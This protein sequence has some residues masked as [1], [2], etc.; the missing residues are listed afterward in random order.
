MELRILIA[1]C[2]AVAQK[3]YRGPLQTLERRR[4]ARIVGVVDYHATHAQSLRTA[5][6][7]AIVFDDLRSGLQK[8]SPHLTLVLTPAHLHAEH[9]QESFRY[10]SNVLCEKPMATSTHDCEQ[11]IAAAAT[12]QRLLAV[13]MV[14]RFFPAFHQLRELVQSGAFGTVVSFE[15]REGRRFDWDVT[16]PAAFRRRDDGGTGVLFDIGPHVID[17]L[18]WTFGHLMAKKYADDAGQGVDSNVILEVQS[19]TTS[20]LI[21]LS[22]DSPLRNELRVNGTKLQAVLRVDQFD[23]LAINAA[24][25]F[26]EVSI[27]PSFAADVKNPSVARYIPHTY[28]QAVYCQLIQMLR[29]IELN[30]SPAVDGVSGLQTIRLLES[31]LALA[32][33]VPMPWL[34]DRQQREYC[35]SHWT[36][37][38][39]STSPSLEPAVLSAPV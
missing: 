12:S 34:S 24:D 10:G 11:M 13:G 7:R 21:H 3:L 5:F 33:P 35:T 38:Q 20:G 23:K 17:Y 29:A 36:N 16:T 14:R 32:Q 19:S 25:R 2:G 15:Y 31:A 27:A 9:T 8:T 1:G 6:P 39:C 26:Q 30:E 22:W 18:Q 37:K 28:P 4:L